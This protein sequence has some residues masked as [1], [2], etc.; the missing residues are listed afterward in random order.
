VWVFGMAF[1]F[2]F[3]FIVNGVIITHSMP[4]PV[5]VFF[6]FTT[7][8]S[9]SARLGQNRRASISSITKKPSSSLIC[10]LAAIVNSRENRCSA[11]TSENSELASCK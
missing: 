3:L 11:S 10:L 4:R 9:S 5:R 8:N 6:C 7:R 2:Y 1:S